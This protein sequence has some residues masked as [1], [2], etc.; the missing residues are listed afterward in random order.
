MVPWRSRGRGCSSLS[1]KNKKPAALEL[2]EDEDDF[3]DD[4][5]I[6]EEEGGPE[7]TPDPVTG[8]IDVKKG[9]SP[10]VG[11]TNE[12]KKK[13]R[14][15]ANLNY[16]P[17]VLC[18]IV[19]SLL[20]SKSVP[21]IERELALTE[22]PNTSSIAKTFP[23]E[24]SLAYNACGGQKADGYVTLAV[25]V[26]ENEHEN[27]PQSKS[28][29]PVDESETKAHKHDV[30]IVHVPGPTEQQ[31]ALATSRAS[32]SSRKPMGFIDSWQA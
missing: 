4:M 6:E 12:K 1:K 2:N 8:L 16:I 25:G 29:E 30:G 3:S 15:N 22:L 27:E 20:R 11:G 31:R 24:F 18:F 21:E 23:D 32:R 17:P 13:I 26:S 14:A 5:D 28:K 9:S 19:N 7:F 10:N